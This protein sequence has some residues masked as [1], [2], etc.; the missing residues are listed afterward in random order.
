MCYKRY[1]LLAKFIHRPRIHCGGSTAVDNK[2]ILLIVVE[3]SLIKRL[4]AY[5][6]DPPCYILININSN[7]MT[8]Y[9]CQVHM[10]TP[11]IPLKWLQ[12]DRFFHSAHNFHILIWSKILHFFPFF[13]TNDGVH[14]FCDAALV[15]RPSAGKKSLRLFLC[16]S[17]SF[18]CYI[19]TSSG[20]KPQDFVSGSCLCQ[21]FY[22]L[23][24]Q[25]FDYCGETDLSIELEQ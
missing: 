13:Y 5:E 7:Q 4:L 18:W 14:T 17:K 6:I 3:H 10:R 20:G 16:G 21:I 19:K 22:L 23:F 1:L 2:I 24:V 12:W 11:E 25:A 15:R 8:I 9:D